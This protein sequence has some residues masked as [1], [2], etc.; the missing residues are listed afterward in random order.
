MP[1]PIGLDG[2]LGYADGH[3]QCSVQSLASMR[4]Q[5]LYSQQM[6]AAIGRD[7]ER[8]SH[9]GDIAFVP[10]PARKTTHQELQDDVN[11]WLEGVLD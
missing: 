2:L 5:E 8:L 4:I 3:N 10:M 6:M 7:R 11:S 1:V 9:S